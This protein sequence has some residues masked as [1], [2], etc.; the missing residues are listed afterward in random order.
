MY[1][2]TLPWSLASLRPPAHFG[3]PASPPARHARK[4]PAAYD[5]TLGADA[6]LE[7]YKVYAMQLCA[8]LALY[9]GTLPSIK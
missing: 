3:Q 1:T 2:Y 6:G 9:T 5:L 8:V 7:R 4:A